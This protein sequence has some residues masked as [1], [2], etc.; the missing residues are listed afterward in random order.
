MKLQDLE[1]LPAFLKHVSIWV[2]FNSEGDSWKLSNSTSTF[3]TRKLG[4][5][6]IKDWVKV[7]LWLKRGVKTPT[8]VSTPQ[9]QCSIH[10]EET[11]IQKHE[12][13]QFADGSATPES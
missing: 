1:Y 3:Q 13:T 9:M 11:Q 2:F 5:T 12:V 7:M 10:T 8:Q 6:E 4:P